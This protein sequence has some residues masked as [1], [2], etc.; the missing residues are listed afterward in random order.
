MKYFRLI[1]C[2]LLI[3]SF[4]G[5]QR[6]NLLGPGSNLDI[7]YYNSFESAEDADGWQGIM[8]EMFVEEPAPNGGEKSLLIGGGCI[9]PTA[10]ITFPKLERS[11]S[12]K[13]SCWGKVREEHQSGMLILRVIDEAENFQSISI[14]LQGN[15][16]KHYETEGSLLCPSG[17]QLRL[18]IMIGG[19]VG[20]S[21]NLDRLTIDMVE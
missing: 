13:L 12:L 3:L 21:M 9:Q 15:E 19:I 7:F 16:W 4:G 6:I 10:S 14:T 5:C 1:F 20:A 11:T 18:E 17:K 8:S 2:L